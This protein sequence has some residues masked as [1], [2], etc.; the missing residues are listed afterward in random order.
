MHAG[1]R[2][3]LR[4]FV[5]IGDLT[6]SSFRMTRLYPKLVPHAEDLEIGLAAPGSTDDEECEPEV[7]QRTTPAPEK[8]AGFSGL[9]DPARAGHFFAQSEQ[10]AN[11]G[12]KVVQK[13][14]GLAPTKAANAMTFSKSLG[15]RGS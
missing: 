15:L 11:E 8:S 5:H 13:P 10:I 14:Q 9:P 12:K 7:V 6:P 2:K 1:E 4:C 3:Q